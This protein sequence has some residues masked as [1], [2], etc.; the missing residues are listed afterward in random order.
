MCNLDR[1]QRLTHPRMYSIHP[2]NIYRLGFAT[3]RGWFDFNKPLQSVSNK[4]GTNIHAVPVPND[5]L[6]KTMWDWNV[7][8]QIKFQL[9]SYIPIQ[10]TITY[11]CMRN[12]P[13][14]WC[15]GTRVLDWAPY[16]NDTG[17]KTLISLSL[18]LFLADSRRWF[19]INMILTEIPVRIDTNRI[20]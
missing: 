19:S 11:Y 3:P 1:A 15:R 10:S 9:V 18:S 16:D 7:Y 2:Q 13:F 8:A 4:D 12:G 6:P 17:H 5:P 20:S 14:L